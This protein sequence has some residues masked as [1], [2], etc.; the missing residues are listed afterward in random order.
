MD[1]FEGTAIAIGAMATVYSHAYAAARGE[2][3]QLPENC[4]A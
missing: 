3:A 1:D 2:R 4:D